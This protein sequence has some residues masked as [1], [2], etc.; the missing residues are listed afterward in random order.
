MFGLELKQQSLS[1]FEENIFFENGNWINKLYSEQKN[2]N[3]PMLQTPLG[4]IQVQVW[5]QGSFLCRY[6]EY[7]KSKQDNEIMD[8]LNW[9]KNAWYI[10]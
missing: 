9:I 10:I 5:P 7:I 3:L 1:S 6:S 8:E 2:L 4:R